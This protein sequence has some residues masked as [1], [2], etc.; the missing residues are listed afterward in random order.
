LKSGEGARI[1]ECRVKRAES[2]LKVQSEEC[3]G[4]GVKSEGVESVE[5]GAQISGV[6]VQIE[7]RSVVVKSAECKV[8]NSQ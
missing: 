5:C 8:K 3:R 2:K 1:Y 7:E 4:C 6:G